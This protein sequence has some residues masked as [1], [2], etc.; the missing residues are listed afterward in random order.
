VITVPPQLPSSIPTPI[1]FIGEA[2]SWDEEL[3]GKPFTGPSGRLFN[4][5]LRS[6]GIDREEC[7]VTNVFSEKLPDNDVGNWCSNLRDA[8]A[9]G[10]SDLAPIGASGFLQPAYRHHLDRLKGELEQCQPK[11][12][13][14]LGGTALWSLTG[15][16][17]IGSVRGT[18][19][20][21]TAL[22]PGAKLLPTWH[23]TFVMKQFKFYPVVVGD[24]QKAL[25]ESKRDGIFL[26]TR[27]LILA[28]TLDQVRDAVPRLLD[29]DLLS[30]D[31]ETAWGQITCIGFSPSPEYGICIPFVDRRNLSRSYWPTA[32]D[33]VRAWSYSRYILASDV[34]KLGQNF[35]GYDFFWL[36]EKYRLA[37]RNV[38]EDTRL[39]HHALFAEL[40][41]SLEFMQGYGT[42]GAWKYMGK[43]KEKKDD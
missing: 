31:I 25:Q 23:P 43:H 12:V 27:E 16:S 22:L 39:I 14:P 2:P 19:T 38:K 7:L 34:P 40:P 32:E 29:T 20:A 28:P 9:G 30:V 6:A 24:L 18:V 1:A 15:S 17:N 33:E 5:L 4:S 41:K 35:G 21:A 3:K 8:R 26:P 36:L 10:F 42:Q 13:V 37:V 11:V